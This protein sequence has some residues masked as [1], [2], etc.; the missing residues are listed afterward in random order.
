MKNNIHKV[1]RQKKQDVIENIAGLKAKRD[2]VDEAHTQIRP[3]IKEA[4]RFGIV[5]KEYPN[6]TKFRV[7]ALFE[8]YPE[9]Y[10]G[11]AEETQWSPSLYETGGAV[12]N[13]NTS[14]CNYLVKA[15]VK[16]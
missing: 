15:T 2:R 5:R 14:G 9:M 16:V 3:L 7:E 8:S 12:C 4:A 10:R 1:F 6:H 13:L 11:I